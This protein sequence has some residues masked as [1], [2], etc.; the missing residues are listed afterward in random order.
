M[1]GSQP[2]PWCYRT[3]YSLIDRT[4]TEATHARLCSSAGMKRL[5]RCAKHRDN[6]ACACQTYKYC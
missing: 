6:H 2:L 1:T 4:V 5:S 3:E